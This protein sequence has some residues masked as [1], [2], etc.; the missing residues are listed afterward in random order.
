MNGLRQHGAGGLVTGTTRLTQHRLQV[1][2]HIV[3]GHH[4]S[5]GR[6]VAA[7]PPTQLLGALKALV[8]V[9]SQ[10][11]AN[12]LFQ[13]DR[14][15][16]IQR[17]QRRNL[18]FPNELKGV[19]VGIALKQTPPC[20]HLPEHDSGSKDVGAAVN[21][22][23]QR[24]LGGQVAEFALDHPGVGHRDLRGCLGKPKV[25]Q[26][27]LAGPRQEDIRRAHVTVHNVQVAPPRVRPVVCVIQSLTDLHRD[28]HGN[29]HR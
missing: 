2:R 6:Q 3:G 25:G 21:R 5:R 24:G 28:V 14:H 12:H 8:R 20:Q 16:W 4:R 18:G 19:P 9:T 15:R 10:R 7:Q 27:Y 23:A 1:G 17:A 26:L 11:T 29:G 13:L 22:L